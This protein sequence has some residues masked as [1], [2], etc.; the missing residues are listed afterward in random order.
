[1]TTQSVATNLNGQILCG[2][3]AA[4]SLFNVGHDKTATNAVKLTYFHI[5]V[6]FSCFEST[7]CYWDASFVGSLQ[8]SVQ[9]AEKTA[10]VMST[11]LLTSDWTYESVDCHFDFLAV[12]DATRKSIQTSNYNIDRGILTMLA[13]NYFQEQS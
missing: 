11:S 5:P 1:M 10:A 9:L 7:G 2:E 3:N 6:P 13:S 12:D 4:D 8:V